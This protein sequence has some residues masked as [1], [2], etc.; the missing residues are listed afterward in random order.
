[1]IE[2]CTKTDIELVIASRRRSR[3]SGR[4][5]VANTL[6]FYDKIAM[7]ALGGLAMTA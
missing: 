6:I 7:S 4:F 1:M 2:E 5:A 3:A